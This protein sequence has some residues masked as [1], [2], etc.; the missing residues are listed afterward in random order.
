MFA[1]ELLQPVLT[2]VK[3]LVEQCG[4]FDVVFDAFVIAVDL[5]DEVMVHGLATIAAD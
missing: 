2:A 3:L 5:D 4:V 1:V